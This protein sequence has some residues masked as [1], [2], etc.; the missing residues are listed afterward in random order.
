MISAEVITYDKL[1]ILMVKLICMYVCFLSGKSSMP[2]IRL[3]Q[4]FLP[5]ALTGEQLAM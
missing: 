3:P 5:P 2:Q 1:Q 4:A